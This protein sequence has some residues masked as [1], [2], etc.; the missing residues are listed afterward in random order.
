MND[1]KETV[2]GIVGACVYRWSFI[3][4]IVNVTNGKK[5]VGQTIQ[6]YR[7]RMQHH[8]NQ[9]DNCRILNRAIA[10]HGWGNFRDTIIIQC[11]MTKPQRDAYE[12]Q[13]IAHHKCFGK[14]TGYNCDTGGQSGGKRSREWCLEQSKRMKK[15][16]KEGKVRPPLQKNW[17][18]S[19]EFAN[20][21]KV[22]KKSGM[23]ICDLARKYMSEGG[24][25]SENSARNCI[26]SLLRPAYGLN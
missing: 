1:P 20:R 14:H 2:P 18:V 3:Y 11:Y 9:N 21:V 4:L 7:E 24:W 17:K 22:D 15:K 19:I 26:Y 12:R 25:N 23:G 6:R 8:R 5:Y 16:Y 13:F 10:K